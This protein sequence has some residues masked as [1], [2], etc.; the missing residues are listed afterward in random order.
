MPSEL[1]SRTE[2]SSPI[3]STGD[4]Q[5]ALAACGCLLLHFREGA[6]L[7]PLRAGQPVIV[8][9]GEEADVM[10]EDRSLSRLHAEFVL[11]QD[12]LLRVRDLGSTNGTHVRGR[13]IESAEIAGDTEATLGGVIASLHWLKPRGAGL[14]DLELH[15]AFVASAER[16]LVRARF[17]KRSFALL[18]VRR[19]EEEE[20]PLRKWAP[21]VQ[22]LQR[23]VDR[24]AVY[25]P[26]TLELLLPEASTELALAFAHELI[27][28]SKGALLVGLAL[29]PQAQSVEE[30]I[31]S[32][33]EALSRAN[34][35]QPALVHAA[36]P[37]RVLAAQEKATGPSC[38]SPAMKELMRT[39]AR[40]ARGTIPLL[41][42]AE[43]GAGKEVLA[44]SLHEASPRSAA[45]ML[46][47]NC[48]AIPETLLESTLFGHEK[49]A[50]TGA[51]SQHR[52][53]FESAS[54]GTV[55]LDEIGELPLSAQAA[56][57][58]VLES[59]T[60]TRV[61][62]TKELAV[63]VRVIAATH[64]D[65][66]R[67][68]EQGRFREDL[69]YRLNAMTLEIPPLRERKEDLP[70]LVQRFLCEAAER[71]GTALPT[72]S[73][74]AMTLLA[75]HSWPGNVRELKNVIERAVVICES[76]VIGVEDL[77][78]H[79]LG[80]RSASSKAPQVPASPATGVPSQPQASPPPAQLANKLGLPLDPG[81]DFRSI[82]ERLEAEVLT[83]ALRQ[84][85]WNQT[86]AARLLQMPLRTLVHKLKSH[87][88]RKLGY[89]K[90]E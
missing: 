90:S 17:F 5:A 4:T 38:E 2:Q 36:A 13:R 34:P 75:A 73:A 89:G 87:N 88:L 82:M 1:G 54:G 50:F 22:E 16:E 61:G 76:N 62:A 35:A 3:D 12:G 7:V 31:G 84:S 40:A 43:T 19:R 30:L 29:F 49:G 41:L 59:K 72:I 74:E 14:R 67:M 9:R 8:G 44:R 28:A 66:Q 21:L 25:G 26:S 69:L 37:F 48:A 56:L 32:A 79:L 55:F 45:P 42:L 57:L 68:V 85:E 80:Q 23:A 24:V 77:P 86:K 81:D 11:T 6:K 60:I 46:S 15:E 27:A 70:V 51:H 53:V 63:D 71:N 83:E 64:R 78:L 65:L 52:G 39:A 10:L 47:V 33:Q 58:R 20:L 18:M